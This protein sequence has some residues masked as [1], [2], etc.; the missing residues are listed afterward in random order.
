MWGTTAFNFVYSVMVMARWT[1]S[2]QPKTQLALLW[3]FYDLFDRLDSYLIWFYP[4]IYL[5]W[6]SKKHI[7]RE[8][9]FE[10]VVEN[11]NWTLSNASS[12]DYSQSMRGGS[13]Y[14]ARSSVNSSSSS[15]DEYDYSNMGTG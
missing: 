9:R 1:D 3:N 12:S 6:P 5:F 2:C 8:K 15:D 11:I 10:K 14:N 13:A 7:Q 4:L